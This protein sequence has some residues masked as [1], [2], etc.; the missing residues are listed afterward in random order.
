MKAIQELQS[1]LYSDVDYYEKMQRF[2][3]FKLSKGN[4]FKDIDGNTVLDLNAS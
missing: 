1:P 3:N 2:V 4:Y